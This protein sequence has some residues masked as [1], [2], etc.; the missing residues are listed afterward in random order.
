MGIFSVACGYHSFETVKVSAAGTFN[1]ITVHSKFRKRHVMLV[2]GAKLGGPL[3]REVIVLDKERIC[4]RKI[5]TNQSE[6]MVRHEQEV[7][8]GSTHGPFTTY[9]IDHHVV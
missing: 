3:S 8:L 2:Y 6:S 4:V 1:L 7:K 9:P 5:E